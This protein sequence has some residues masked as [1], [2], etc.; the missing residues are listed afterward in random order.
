VSDRVF[1]LKEVAQAHRYIAERRN[2]GKGVLA[3]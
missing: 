1:P 2:F 3:P